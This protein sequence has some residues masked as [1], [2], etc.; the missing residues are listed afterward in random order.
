MVLSGT[1][2]TAKG[3]SGPDR[4]LDGE[5]QCLRPALPPQSSLGEDSPSPPTAHSHFPVPPRSWLSQFAQMPLGVDPQP[6]DPGACWP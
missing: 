1:R 2:P 6:G 3:Q 4:G 5:E